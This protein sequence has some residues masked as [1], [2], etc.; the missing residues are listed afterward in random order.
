MPPYRTFLHSLRRSHDVFIQKGCICEVNDTV[1]SIIGF[2]IENSPARVAIPL[3][4]I[5]AVETNGAFV[6]GICCVQIITLNDLY[7]LYC[8]DLGGEYN[9][10]LTPGYRLEDEIRTRA[11]LKPRL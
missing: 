8:R 1:L 4:N 10:D 2:P 5:R 9:D 11:G 6:L 3:D 7:L